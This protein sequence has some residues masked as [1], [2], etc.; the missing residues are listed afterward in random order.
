MVQ[1]LLLD[2][3]WCAAVSMRESAAFDYENFIKVFIFR[4]IREGDTNLL[5]ALSVCVVLKVVNC[6]RFRAF[7]LF[8]DVFKSNIIS[9]SLN[10]GSTAWHYP[11]YKTGIHI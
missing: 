9:T 6:T 7:L 10:M 11:L 2:G 8:Y 5:F 4:K 1:L 3:L